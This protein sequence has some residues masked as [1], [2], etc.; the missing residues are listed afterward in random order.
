[1]S[2]LL[3]APCPRYAHACAKHTPVPS[4]T[5]AR[6]CSL[7]CTH[8]VSVCLPLN[9]HHP[10]H[11]LTRTRACSPTTTTLPIPSPTLLVAA[12]AESSTLTP[13]EPLP[14][15]AASASLDSGTRPYL[16]HR[17]NAFGWPAL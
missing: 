12:M 8:E 6:P 7:A 4:L 11:L 2:P 1:M 5:F 3:T 14:A 9:L 13:V 17:S 15:P 10:A 16:H